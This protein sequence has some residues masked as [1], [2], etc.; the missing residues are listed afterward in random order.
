[1][2]TVLLNTISLD[3]GRII[4][5]GGSGGG[6][7]TPG[8]GGT[9]PDM[10]VIGDGKTYLYI[11]IAEKGRMNVPL[12]FS[13]TVANGVTIDWGDG[14]TPQTLSGTGNKNT[15]HTY[16]D[17][18][19]Y[20]ISLN[21]ADG[22]TMGLGNYISYNSYYAVMG[23]TQND[24]T[25]YRNMLKTV[26]IGNNVTLIDEYAFSKCYSLLSVVIS[27]SVTKIND[28]AFAY[29]YNLTHLKIGNSVEKIGSHAFENCY[30]LLNIDIPNS[31]KSIGS[32]AFINCKM[33]SSIAIPEGVTSIGDSVC[34]GCT[35]L[36]S[37]VIPDSVK[38][39]GNNAFENCASLNSVVIGDGVTS[40]NNG[41][42]YLC[43]TLSDVK[44]SNNVTSLGSVFEGC[45]SLWH[46]R[47][48]CIRVESC[49]SEN[50]R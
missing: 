28:N 10:P 4:K 45:W 12:Y 24:N 38:S 20:V 31:V 43:Y 29:C 7:N 8:G 23:S 39:L 37:I 25:I 49:P 41:T 27:D 42:F 32:K 9:T 19:E 16:A 35:S 15:T 6:G 26:E 47:E 18:G 33:L 11:K 21:P 2:N 14:S 17:K 36:T 22:C 50:Q 44:I 34:S 30:C 13:Q 40:L 5:K 1:M 48:S 3:D 46:H